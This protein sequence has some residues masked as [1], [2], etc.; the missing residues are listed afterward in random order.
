MHKDLASVKATVYDYQQWEYKEIQRIFEDFGS[1]WD[2]RGKLV[3]DIG[4]GL[5]GKLP[6]Y[7]E[8]GATGVVGIDLRPQSA[9]AAHRFGATQNRTPNNCSK[10]H[11]ATANGSTLPFH[12][13]S[14]DVVV[15]INVLEHVMDPR[16]VLRECRRVLRS[17]G[18]LFLFFPPFYSPWGAHL[19][20]WIDFPWPHL[21]FPD[22]D[23]VQAAAQVEARKQLNDRF[24]PSAQVH[25]GSLDELPELSRLSLRQFRRLVQVE[26]LVETQCYL[27]PFGRHL[28]AKG[29]VC[30][31]ILRFLHVLTRIPLLNELIVTKIAC[32]MSKEG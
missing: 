9:L 5:G 14:F 1:H 23:L 26:R 18:Q 19:D 4:C 32:V 15:S 11:T 10:I 29:S 12:D 28:L 21:F 31:L 20:G 27:L 2:L 17:Q 3:L 25:W 24:I 13:N 16:A 30:R 8:Q 22:R 6:F 7:V